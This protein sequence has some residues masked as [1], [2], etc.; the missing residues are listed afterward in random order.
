ML[1]TLVVKTEELRKTM[2]WLMG[3]ISDSQPT[4]MLFLCGGSVTIGII[5]LWRIANSLNI[6]TL[7]EYESKGLGIDTEQ[8]KLIA[9]TFAAFITAIAV[10]VSGLIGF[11]GLI[12]PH[13]TRLIFGPD[14]RQLIPLSA[15]YGGIFLT[16]ADT[17]ARTAFGQEQFPVGVITAITGGPFFIIL[18]VRYTRKISWM[19]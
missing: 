5:V 15:I 2:Y 13:A 7:G 12:V 10:S 16:I 18:L 11:V 17:I 1:L 6:I 8:T 9:F 3:N 19:K 4:I 14:H